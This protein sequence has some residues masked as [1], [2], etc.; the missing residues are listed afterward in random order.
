M[1]KRAEKLKMHQDQSW[2]EMYEVAKQYYLSHGELDVPAAF[3]TPEGKRLGPWLNRQ[4]RVR[5]GKV[6]VTLDNER[7]RKLDAIGMSWIDLAEERWNR[8]FRALHI[9]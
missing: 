5:E 8:N 4:R 3:V 6:S 7:I 1:N 2:N 9:L